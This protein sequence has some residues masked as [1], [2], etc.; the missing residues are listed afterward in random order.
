M[1]LIPLALSLLSRQRRAARYRALHRRFRAYSM[2]QTTAFVENLFLAERVKPIPGCVVECGVWRGGMSA[3]LAAVLGPDRSYFLFDSFEGLPPA[4]EID[5]E[6]ALRWQAEKCG[7]TYHDNCTAGP[8][9]A[10]EAM[11]LSGARNYQLV[12]GWFEKTVPNFRFPG[13]IALLRLDADWY[14]STMVCLEHL[15]GQVAPGGLVV[16]DDYYTWDG[17]ARAVHDYLSR[18]PGGERIRSLGQTCFLQKLAPSDFRPVPAPT[19][20]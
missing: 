18:H 5:G 15:F 14:D 12:Q 7:A 10:R 20:P 2:I 1:N 8:E 17:C 11:E 19:A 4:R 13:L 16:L 3:A 9:F 6:S